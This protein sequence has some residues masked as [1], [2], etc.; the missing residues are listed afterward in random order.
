MVLMDAV[1]DLAVPARAPSNLGLTAVSLDH[2]QISGF[3]SQPVELAIKQLESFNFAKVEA[4]SLDIGHA[5]IWV[6][7][8]V[9]PPL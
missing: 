7:V 2:Q 8:L 3:Q 5:Q 9:G 4:A 1:I 6:M